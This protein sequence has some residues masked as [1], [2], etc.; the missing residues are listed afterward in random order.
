MT[1]ICNVKFEIEDLKIT[2]V[3]TIT[4]QV[5]NLFN[6]FFIQ[7]FRILSQKTREKTKLLTFESLVK[8]LKGKKL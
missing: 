8:S 6:L 2:I 7:F 1:K 5:L 4:I 3:E